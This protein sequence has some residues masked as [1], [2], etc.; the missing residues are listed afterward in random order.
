[1]S[2][3]VVGASGFVG[4]HFIKQLQGEETVGIVAASRQLQ[5]DLKPT[6]KQVQLP[7]RFVELS[8]HDL[9]RMF[10]RITC[11]FH[12]ASAT[13]RALA[14]CS[15]GDRQ[16]ELKDNVEM[17]VFLARAAKARG[18]KRFVYVSSCGIYGAISKLRPFS[19]LSPFEP[20]DSYTASKIGAEKLLA[21]SAN[22]C[23]DITIVRPPAVYGPGGHNALSRLIRLTLRGGRS[24]W[25]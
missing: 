23:P 10:E 11:I 6:V 4:R 18:V 5:P 2:I 19:E 1:M 8:P 17:P 13:P 21:S 12:L 24:Q 25:G 14:N 20:H 16:A 15:E 22:D 7:K 3:L 9:D